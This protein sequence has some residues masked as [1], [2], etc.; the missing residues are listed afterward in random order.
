[1][2]LHRH[3][4]QTS[5][6][7]GAALASSL[8]IAGMASAAPQPLWSLERSTPLSAGSSST[9]AGVSADG[10]WAVLKGAA[11]AAGCTDGATHLFL[12]DTRTGSLSCIDQAPGGAAGN[13][14]V[15]A[16]AIS[17]DGSV[18]V[19]DSSAS[20]LV[21]GDGNGVQDVFAWSRAT[22]ALERVSVTSSG[23]AGS[24]ESSSPAVSGDGRYVAFSS[25]GALA[26]GASG[27]ID[28][29]F[30]RDRLT[31]TT[32][33]LS[34]SAAGDSP[35]NLAPDPDVES[36]P[37]S[38]F[39]THGTATFSWA[40]DQS[41]SP[42]HSLKIVST[43]PAGALARWMT[44]TDAIRVGGGVQ[45]SAS[46]WL[47]A[48][49]VV[50][51]GQLA[52]S[53]WSSAYAYLGTTLASAGSVT[54]SQDWTR[55]SLTGTAPAGA[56]FMRL[57]LRLYGPGSLW[58]DDLSATVGSAS[59][60]PV[61]A[62]G[63]SPSISGDGSSVVFSTRSPA[64]VPGLTSPDDSI[65][66]LDRGTGTFQ[67][68]VTRPPDFTSQGGACHWTTWIGPGT[69]TAD[70]SHVAYPT[71]I[72]TSDCLA[73]VPSVVVF[74]RASGRS[75][76]LFQLLE[77]VARGRW[78]MWYDGTTLL[79]PPSADASRLLFGPSF[80]D[81]GYVVLDRAAR[82]W[83][84]L[85][86]E[87]WS[88][89]MSA[90]G[91]TVVEPD[92][93]I[94]VYRR[95]AAVAA[96]AVVAA[97]AISG[98]AQAG[99]T[100]SGTLG[101]WSGGPTRFYYSWLACA[102]DGSGCV[103]REGVDATSSTV[104]G[105]GSQPAPYVVRPEDA[106]RRIQLR[107]AA[108]TDVALS[109]TDSV[110]TAVVTSALAANLA[111]DPGFEA[112]PGATYSTH[113]SG[114]FTW[115]PFA[116]HSGSRSLKIVSPQPRD[117]LARWMTTT[118]AIPVTPGRSYR[119][120]AWL[121][122]EGVVN[123]GVVSA[124][125]WSSSYAYLGTTL[126]SPAVSGT[127]DWTPLALAATAPAGAAFLRVELR[128]WGPGTLWADDLTV[129]DTTGGPQAPVNTALPT[130]G[131]TPAEGG[132]LTADTGSWTGTPTGYTYA[133]LRCDAGGGNCAPIYNATTGSLSLQADLVG[134]RIRMRVTASNSAGFT[135]ADSSPTAAVTGTAQA[136][137][138]TA[139][140]VI[141]GNAVVGQTLTTSNGTWTGS[142]TGYAYSWALC[143]PR[144]CICA[145]TIAGATGSSYVVTTA[146]V[147][148]R[149]CSVVRAANGAGSS[150]GAISGPTEIV[151]AGGVPSANLAPDPGFES[152][153]A[154]S[155]YTHG[156]G[157]FSWAADDAH[158]GSHSLKVASTQPAGALA[159][160][161]TTTTAI[162][163]QPGRS[164]AISAWL[165][166]LDA[167]GNAQL[168]VSWW[169]SDGTYA[170]VTDGAAQ[171]PSGSQPWTL[172]S[173]TSQAPPGAAYLRLELRLWGPGT[174]WADDATVTAP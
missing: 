14:P 23:V 82:T 2:S 119:V 152:D 53:F 138:N 35:P 150:A 128:L 7:L 88:S 69:V 50:G 36:A 95:D 60:G 104:L 71:S 1:M 158:G 113:G 37:A 85:P 141:T 64:L 98:A 54:G 59:G 168:A 17:G 81:G 167:G 5:L 169:R 25:R 13:G 123:Q 111:P 55:V 38:S 132:T 149:I 99:D 68:V 170:G 21:A 144:D 153:P 121:K 130:I 147:G 125:F 57:E 156:T 84:R 72:N 163:A 63:T 75:A 83:E 159:R 114:T 90:D 140:P 162:P 31:G 67:K 96:P 86:G 139:L 92:G 62:G 89:R 43:Q 134:W 79:G 15:G 148:S 127:Q 93:A 142:P 45:V 155:Y 51:S 48:A 174:L 47:R 161:M 118:D 65:V 166:T 112:D 122:T 77:N 41:H 16:A 22:R 143:N 26:P 8:A 129:T 19:F 173:L 20:N 145:N 164:Y 28:N 27:T 157:T 172:A 40:T 102:V 137:V 94:R 10:R 12:L 58:A 103:A 133:W 154:S 131:G 110:P 126:T 76:E 151:T 52:A 11:L 46:A 80:G 6:A 97:P 120:A 24:A 91:R 160:W 101:S 61:E 124:T 73:D 74:D 109:E 33:L 107:V 42:G 34:A 32:T 39:Y 146:D 70:G 66:A 165:R 44:M 115:D 29:V 116:A 105:P 56:A 108:S 78:G 49:G 106:G 4:A 100:L 136:P 9:V 30:L 87:G 18:V 171:T 117:A 3:L 135:S